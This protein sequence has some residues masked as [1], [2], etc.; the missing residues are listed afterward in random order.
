MT[1]KHFFNKIC[2]IAIGTK[3]KNNV[4]TCVYAR[5][6]I[7]VRMCVRACIDEYS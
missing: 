5:V 1:K 6:Y 2:Q 3:C 7:G 4:R